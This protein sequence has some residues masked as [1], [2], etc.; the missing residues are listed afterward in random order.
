[1]KPNGKHSSSVLLNASCLCN[2]WLLCWMESRPTLTSHLKLHTHTH[3]HTHTTCAKPIRYVHMLQKH[4]RPSCVRWV[5][6]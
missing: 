2:A 6:P 5:R 1:M 3:T 4:S